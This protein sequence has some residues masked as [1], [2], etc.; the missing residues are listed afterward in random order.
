MQ[1]RLQSTPQS[2]GHSGQD[3]PL[4]TARLHSLVQDSPQAAMDV[5]LE[6]NNVFALD[7]RGLILGGASL[8]I[9]G[10]W[11]V[12]IIIVLMKPSARLT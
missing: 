4:Q 5:L 1:R 10:P 2:L 3:R 11:P 8:K 7:G 6:L 12:P 9:G